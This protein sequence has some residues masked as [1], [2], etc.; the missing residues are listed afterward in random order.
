MLENQPAGN[1]WRFRTFEIIF[2]HHTRAGLT[3]DLCLL[4]AIVLSVIV[5]CAE[6]LPQFHLD[7]QSKLKAPLVILNM[8]WWFLAAEVG[9]T[10]LF[11]MR[12]S[13]IKWNINV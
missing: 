2:G 6:T 12:N 3:F 13:T 8:Q 1:G 10:L 11:A 9:F 5:V 4:V 7:S